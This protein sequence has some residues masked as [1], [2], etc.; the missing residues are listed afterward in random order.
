MNKHENF[1]KS[2][3]KQEQDIKYVSDKEPE[4]VEDIRKLFKASNLEKYL[5]KI[6]LLVKPVIE[7][8][9]E[10]NIPNECSK[11]GRKPSLPKDFNWPKTDQQKSMSFIAQ[12]NISDFKKYDEAHLFPENGIISFFYCA[13][14]QAWG[15]SIS[16]F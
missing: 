3:D 10:E 13:D 14:Q 4:T 1:I 8:E 16:K 2:K 11:I 6:E 15:F 5:A 7:F 9:K 12:L